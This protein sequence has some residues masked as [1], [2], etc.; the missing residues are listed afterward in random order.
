MADRFYKLLAWCQGKTVV[1]EF[2]SV[3]HV[4]ENVSAHDC[5]LRNN[6]TI[7]MPLAYH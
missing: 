2:I 1:A 3:Q 7:I 6:F 5:I 4:N